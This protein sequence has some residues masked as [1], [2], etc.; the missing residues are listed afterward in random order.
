MYV[1]VN[2]VQLFF[3]V[4]SAGLVPDGLQM[5]ARPT[6]IVLQGGPGFDHGFFGPDHSPIADSAQVIYLDHR[7]NGR[8]SP[9]TTQHWTLDQWADDLAAFLD[10]LEIEH[11]VILG[12]S[13]GGFVAMNFA[14]RYPQRL[15]KLVLT[16]TSARLRPERSLAVFERLGGAQARDA[17]EAMFNGVNEETA[18]EFFRHC[19]PLYSLAA[20]DPDRFAR[21]RSPPELFRHLLE[22]ILPQM[23]SLPA[24]A[25][26]TCATLVMCGENDPITPI[27]DSADIADALGKNLAGFIRV[28]GARHF[29]R[30]DAPDVYFGH[31][32][33]FIESD[34]D[35][36]KRD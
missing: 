1:S 11:P 30:F 14:T 26:I 36:H 21:V 25:K 7:G 8:S 19:L 33:A 12:M 27:G 35:K 34:A 32:R 5:R 17:A 10:V 16:S 6:L 24:L 18:S 22:G 9:D 3:D 20:L 28:A 31:L 23:D 15:S 4:E 13:F 2:D 29:L